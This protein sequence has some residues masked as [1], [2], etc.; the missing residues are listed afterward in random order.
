MRD[1]VFIKDRRGYLNI[2]NINDETRQIDKNSVIV[3]GGH[4]IVCGTPWNMPIKIQTR[5]G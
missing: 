4:Q 1:N 3:D 2:N 5:Y